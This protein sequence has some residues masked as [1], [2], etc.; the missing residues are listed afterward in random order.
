MC[1]NTKE[2]LCCLV[3]NFVFFS[4]VKPG[5]EELKKPNISAGEKKVKKYKGKILEK[6]QSSMGGQ[7]KQGQC[8]GLR[9]SQTLTCIRFAWE[10]KRILNHY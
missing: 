8:R 10:F 2:F 1:L 3:L 4:R 6:G 7:E 5:D 9:Y